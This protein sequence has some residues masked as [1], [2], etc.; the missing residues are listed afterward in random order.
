MNCFFKGNYLNDCIFY[1]IYIGSEEGSIFNINNRMFVSI[2]RN[3]LFY[4]IFYLFWDLL[5]EYILVIFKMV[6]YFI[7][8]CNLMIY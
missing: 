4:V 5:V 2:K 1:Y 6:L 7:F 3:S 8:V